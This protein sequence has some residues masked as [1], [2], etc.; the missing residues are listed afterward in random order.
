MSKVSQ[1]FL[2]FD[3][4]KMHTLI[5]L[6]RKTFS[7]SYEKQAENIKISFTDEFEWVIINNVLDQYID[8]AIAHELVVEDVCPY[9]ILA[10]Y[11]YFLANALYLEQK[12]L[13]I[14]SISTSIICMLRLLE[15]ENIKLE[16]AFHKKALKM[17][18]FE[19]KGSHMKSEE[20]NRK[21]YTKI[22][23]GMNGLYMMFRTAS[24]CKKT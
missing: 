4:K 1:P 6:F 9:K 8:Y 16:E 22:G 14:L 2:H 12:E 24:I 15:V 10:W 3:A 11:G 18:L 21:E 20:C 19:L 23:L 7:E 13:S 17:I 5:L